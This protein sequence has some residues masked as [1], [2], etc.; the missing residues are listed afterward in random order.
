MVWD[1]PSLSRQ[2]TN[3]RAIKMQ[4]KDASKKKK[5]WA[6]HVYK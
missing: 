1:T 5:K 4:R 3:Q 6:I 2:V